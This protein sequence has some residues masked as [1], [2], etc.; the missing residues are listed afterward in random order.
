MAV[1]F[2]GSAQE[3]IVDP[4]SRT[5]SWLS[6]KYFYK[7]DYLAENQV[8]EVSVLGW[9][10][11]GTVSVLVYTAIHQYNRN[12][13][14]SYFQFNEHMIYG[15]EPIKNEKKRK[16][17]HQ[18]MTTTEKFI[19]K[20][21]ENHQLTECIEIYKEGMSDGSTFNHE[22]NLNYTSGQLVE[23]TAKNYYADSTKSPEKWDIDIW[24]TVYTYSSKD[25]IKEYTTNKSVYAK[26]PETKY[27][28]CN[29]HYSDLFNKT[30]ELD[31]A[32]YNKEGKL[33][34][35]VKDMHPHS[36]GPKK[37]RQYRYTYDDHG[38]L[39]SIITTSEGKVLKEEVVH[40]NDNGLIN[41]VIYKN[42][43]VFYFENEFYEN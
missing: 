35:F 28:E 23:Q 11:D 9:A 34:Y 33:L 16:K 32:Q 4:Y 17:V 10:Q 41:K 40:Y 43:M 22:H 29:C 3:I 24:N 15:L 7:Q 36:F 25:T 26:D 30:Y 39:K 27:H 14:P 19:F 38:K 37:Y 13:Q 1:Q 2:L 5:Q 6:P 18:E 42:D 8:K 12:G 21:N 31:S 20:Y